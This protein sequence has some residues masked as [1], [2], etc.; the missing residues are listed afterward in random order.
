MDK[1]ATPKEGL[2]EVSVA[3]RMAGDISDE[4]LIY[5]RL[6]LIYLT[7]QRVLVLF[8]FKQVYFQ[9]S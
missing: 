2:A 7:Q 9:K 1:Q 3:E 4:Q 8:P 5:Y 6:L